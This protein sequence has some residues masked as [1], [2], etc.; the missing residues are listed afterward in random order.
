MHPRVA[1]VHDWLNGMRGGEKVLQGLAHLFPEAPIHALVHEPG[2]LS[3]DLAARAIR[4]SFVQWLPGAPRKFRRYLPLFPAA[5]ASWDL[6]AYDWVVSSSHCVALG[7]RPRPGALHVCYCH[8]PMRYV[9]DREADYRAAVPAPARPA[10]AALAAAL[11]AWDRRAARGVDR[12]LANSRAVAD[13]IRRHYG[14]TAALVPP[15]VDLERFAP[16]EGARDGFY[17]V[18]SALVPYKRVDLA[19]RACSEA[20]RPLWVAGTGPELRRLERIAGP[21][22]RFLGWVADADLPGLYARAR[23]FLFPGEEDFGITPLEA[24]ASGCPVIAYRAG[25]VLD[26]VAG[27]GDPGGPTGIL[28]DA[29]TVESLRGGM[30]RLESGAVRFDPQALRRHAARFDRPRFLE[31]LR[32]SLADAWREHGGDPHDLPW[33]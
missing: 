11:R 23:A 20:G 21:T 2:T 12:F 19:V 1:L 18:V 5:A 15:P 17:L 32:G 25:G 24:A 14:R 16:P 26:T 22:V 31:R 28:F 7:A 33:V 27:E 9:W 10:A 30:D 13:R 8:T 29:Q 6:G 3:E 4:T